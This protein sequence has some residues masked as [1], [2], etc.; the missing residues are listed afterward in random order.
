MT[1]PKTLLVPTDFGEPSEVALQYAVE[2]AS[3]LGADIVVMHAFEIPIVGFP[4]GSLVATADVMSHILEG[5]ETGLE[6]AIKRH[7]SAGVPMRTLVRQGEPWQMVI[8][9]ANE[10]GAGLVVMGTHGR[11]GLPR[12]LLGSVAERVVRTC[13][14][15]VLTV[16]SQTEPQSKRGRKQAAEA[17][18]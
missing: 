5:A 8:D 14:I 4:D 13:T 7:R 6:T 17:S 1:L 3:K 16:H 10:V 2:L 11:R 12:A 15:P 9:V 18:P